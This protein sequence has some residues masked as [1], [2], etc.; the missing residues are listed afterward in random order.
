MR[1]GRGW[2]PHAS[3]REGVSRGRRRLGEGA[4]RARLACWAPSGL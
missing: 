3:E 2:G 4:G 1:G